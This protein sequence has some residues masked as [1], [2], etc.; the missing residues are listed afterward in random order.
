MTVSL[1]GLGRAGA[2]LHHV[3]L[4]PGAKTQSCSPLF[5][6]VWVWS[7]SNKFSSTPHLA[8]SLRTSQP[9]S[10]IR[11]PGRKRRSASAVVLQPAGHK[12]KLSITNSWRLP[13]GHRL[14]K[15][16]SSPEEVEV[17]ASAHKR[18]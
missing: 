15:L 16:H 17:A 13:H 10:Q 9:A 1:G 2:L 18:G 8:I 7:L 4:I 11:G 3:L 14:P 6:K 12:Q 5:T